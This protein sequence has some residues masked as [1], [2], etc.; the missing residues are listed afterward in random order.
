MYVYTHTHTHS[1]QIVQQI[2]QEVNTWTQANDQLELY[3][4][5]LFLQIPISLKLFSNKKL[6]KKKLRNIFISFEGK[7]ETALS[8]QKYSNLGWGDLEKITKL[9]ARNFTLPNLCLT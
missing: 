3:V 2:G 9:K 8:L 6:K 7:V 5:V 4:F 1:K